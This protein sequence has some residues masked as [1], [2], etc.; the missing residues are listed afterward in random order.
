MLCYLIQFHSD[1][2]GFSTVFAVTFAV[3]L[4]RSALGTAKLYL[5]SKDSFAP[6]VSDFCS[7][8]YSGSIFLTDQPKIAACMDAVTFDTKCL[9]APYRLR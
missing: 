3:N 2:F 9:T 7:R 4:L 5:M 1:V 6:T 8:G